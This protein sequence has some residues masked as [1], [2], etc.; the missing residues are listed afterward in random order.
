MDP[1]SGPYIVQIISVIAIG[2]FLPGLVIGGILAA[3]AL[4][5]KERAL[6]IREKEL[7]LEREKL[8]FATVREG[9]QAIERAGELAPRI[10]APGA[11]L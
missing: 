9:R 3:R 5:L 6:T 2:V 8:S 7:E 10:S 4:R 11:R 1:I